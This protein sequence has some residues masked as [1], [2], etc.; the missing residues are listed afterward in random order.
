MFSHSKF[1]QVEEAQI[2]NEQPHIMTKPAGR[3]PSLYLKNK[4][5]HSRLSD[6]DGGINHSADNCFK[7]Q[8]GI[9]TFTPSPRL[10]GGNRERFNSAAHQL[11]NSNI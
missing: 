5:V 10:T 11:L 6:G 2:V 8:S 1:N 4:A 9:S 7:T 3:A